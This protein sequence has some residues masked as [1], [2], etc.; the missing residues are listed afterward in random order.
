M[1]MV[2]SLKEDPVPLSLTHRRTVDV[3][4]ERS[5]F[6]FLTGCDVVSLNALSHFTSDHSID[7]GC[8]IFGPLRVQ[9]FVLARLTHLILPVKASIED[10][11]QLVG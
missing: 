2:A 5:M 6:D 7:Q 11:D 10:Y 9:V 4:G 8:F 1:L 3:S